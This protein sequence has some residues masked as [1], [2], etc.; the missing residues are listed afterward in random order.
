MVRRNLRLAA[1]VLGML[2][3]TPAIARAAVDW[4]YPG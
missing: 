2:V 3:I 4:S 1:L